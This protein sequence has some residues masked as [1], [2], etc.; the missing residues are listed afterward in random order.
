MGLCVQRCRRGDVD[1]GRGVGFECETAGFEGCDDGGPRAQ[2][3]EDVV[4]EVGCDEEYRAE[5][6]VGQIYIT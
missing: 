3:N 5:G 4:G 2:G 6:E 1:K